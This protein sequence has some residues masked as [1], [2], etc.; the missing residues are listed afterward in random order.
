MKRRFTGRA[1]IAA[2][3]MTVA[4][5]AGSVTPASA[6]TGA[7]A[8]SIL[9][10]SSGGIVH[11]CESLT[12]DNAGGTSP[13]GYQ[14]VVCVDIHTGTYPGGYDAWGEVE[15]FCT[16]GLTAVTV[17]CH[18]IYIEGQFANAD[19]T[20]D[21]N[22]WSCIGTCDSG[23]QTLYIGTFNYTGGKDCASSL[24]HNV[25]TVAVENT[26]I[27]TPDNWGFG[28]TPNYSSG[29]YWVCP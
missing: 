12:R 11:H 22:S 14:A 19:N 21:N 28:P 25:W 29:H 3:V 4:A 7:D 2:A 20:V 23:R 27:V 6:A 10:A 1:L 16:A 15:A 26:F 17:P 8:S 13:G 24:G 5:L 9:N 18:T